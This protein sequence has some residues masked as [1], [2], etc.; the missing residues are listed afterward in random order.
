[1]SF[2]LTGKV[3]INEI[4]KG[5]DGLSAYEIWLNAGNEG[6]EE[7]FLA[8]LIGEKGDTGEKGDKGEKGDPGDKGDQGE[9]GDKGDPGAKGEKG[10]KGDKG[11]T[12]AKGD[13]GDKGDTGATG[14]QGPQGEKGEPG[15]DAELPV[16]TESD[17]GKFLQ[18]VGG[19]WV[20]ASITN[21]NE[22]E[23]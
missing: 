8:S 7:D 10:D 3:K 18:V 6:T 1:M 5:A 19:K 4:V 21:G 9:K 20:A 14:P 13:K 11:D 22:V 17:D 12:G 2:G 15:K 23:Y 16:V